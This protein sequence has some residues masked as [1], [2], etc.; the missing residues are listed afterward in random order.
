MKEKLH[1]LLILF[2]AVSLVSCSKDGAEGP[3]GPEGKIG[4]EGVAGKQGVPGTDGKMIHYGNT[5]PTASIGNEG[6]FYINQSTSYLY[7]PK[8]PTS[9]GTGIN[10][11]GETGARGA[12]GAKGDKGD[13]GAAGKDGVKGDK[14]DTGARG[15]TG[16]AGSQFLSG[17][18]DPTLNQGKAGDFFFNTTSGTL[19]G[20][21]TSTWLAGVNLKG[22]KGDKGEQGDRGPA[23]QVGPQGP[24]GDPGN[25]GVTSTAWI[26]LPADRWNE[27]LIGEGTTRFKEPGDLPGTMVASRAFSIAA[28]NRNGVILVYVDDGRGIRL[29]P[30]DTPIDLGLTDPR[31]A[32]VRF[33][34]H[35]N[36]DFVSVVVSPKTTTWP[37]GRIGLAKD[38]AA[39]IKFKLV[40]IPA[41]IAQAK[42]DAMKK[43]DLNNLSA[44]TQLFDLKH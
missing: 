25:M 19:F 31:T 41:A 27:F 22:L 13:T 15:A 6:D 39:K 44:V 14:G 26:S 10:L 35:T 2:L 30:F 9:W 23:G 43:I 17:A 34:V 20:P 37:T 18:S 3:I 7:G 36:Q 1:Y 42:A 11:K 4:K 32:S 33:V 40:V 28:A 29:P 16:T 38:Q 21:K 8:T 5:A 24:K 12:T